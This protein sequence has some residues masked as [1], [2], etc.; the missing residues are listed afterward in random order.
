[1]SF[2]YRTERWRQHHAA[3]CIQALYK[4]YAVRKT[5]RTIRAQAVYEDDDD[6]EYEAVSHHNG[7]EKYAS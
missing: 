6:F 5:L 1:M 3:V 2:R 7:V 4:G